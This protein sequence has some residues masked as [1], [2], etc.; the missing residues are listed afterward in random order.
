MLGC[1]WLGLLVQ[2]VTK[3]SLEDYCQANIFG[4]L[5]MTN[6]TFFPFSRDQ[7]SR[8]MPLR[9]FNVNSGEYEELITQH[10]GLTLPRR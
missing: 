7:R 2:A 3:S 8:L 9:W 4:P 1:R 10:P 6:S 5:G